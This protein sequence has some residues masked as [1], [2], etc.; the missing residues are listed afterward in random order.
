MNA[1]SSDR[2]RSV[3]VFLAA[4]AALA[5]LAPAC[6]GGGEGDDGMDAGTDADADTDTDTGTGSS[7]D[8]DADS[9]SDTDSVVEVVDFWVD[10]I[11][12]GEVDSMQ[13]VRGEDGG[14]AA[15]GTRKVTG[16]FAS[17][18]GGGGP[19]SPGCAEAF[20]FALTEAQAAG[21]EPALA[22]VHGCSCEMESDTSTP[23]G[24][25]VYLS[26]DGELAYSAFCTSFH[27]SMTSLAKVMAILDRV[28]MDE[29]NG[30]CL[31][32]L[33]FSRGAEYLST[34][35]CAADGALISAQLYRWT[36][37]DVDYF[38]LAEGELASMGDA[39][40]PEAVPVG[41]IALTDE[42]AEAL[43]S[44]SVALP[45]PELEPP[46]PETCAAVESCGSEH[47]E[48]SPLLY[49]DEFL[50]DYYSGYITTWELSCRDEWADPAD[51]EAAVQL[52]QALRDLF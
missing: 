37:N 30:A 11:F 16:H 20:S 15:S 4:L 2:A 35:G 48:V 34:P 42:E 40:T 51:A 46:V 36:E 43:L 32:Y 8:T 12:S 52:E 41:P 7:S 25:F 6:G 19:S 21:L 50:W 1:S 17:M 33:S 45:S 18:Y 14:L 22:A 10:H 9:D 47:I 3:L 28:A 5:A 31:S 26:I 44:L 39:G 24:V 23:A 49:R 13:V 38:W 27:C 29:S